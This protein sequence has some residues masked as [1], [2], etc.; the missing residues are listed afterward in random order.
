MANRQIDFTGP[1]LHDLGIN[2]NKGITQKGN[3]DI[4]NTENTNMENDSITS[5]PT[6]PRGKINKENATTNNGN[7]K[8]GNGKIITEKNS[9]TEPEFKKSRI[10]ITDNGNT[11]IPNTTDGYAKR[12]YNTVQF[13]LIRDY[14][15]AALGDDDRAE[16]KISVMGSELGINPKTLYKHL[17]TLRNTE[18]T[19]TK[20]QYATEI[21]RR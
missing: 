15:Y 5:E 20:L 2:P 7:I 8:S 4:G 14:L 1:S 3:G 12:T 10:S 9:F 21:K 16:I 19:I 11:E 18:F 6:K 17:R 13:R